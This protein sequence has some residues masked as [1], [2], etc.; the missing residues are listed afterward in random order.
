VSRVQVTLVAQDSQRVKVTWP[1]WLPYDISLPAVD[2]CAREI[3]RHL[4]AL[5]DAA[6]DNRLMACAKTLSAI[7]TVGNDLYLALFTKISGDG[8]PARIRDY[9]E[10]RPDIE[11]QFF[12][13]NMIFVPWGL[14]Y[15]SD[16]SSLPEVW[17]NDAA[18]L[19]WE[20]YLGFWCF[21]RA[22][23]ITYDRVEM[24]AVGD[25]SA[26]RMMCVVNP[27]VLA[28]AEQAVMAMPEKGLLHWLTENNP[29]SSWKTL[30]A[31]WQT[32][33]AKVGLLYFYCHASAT[34]LALG[35]EEGIDSTQLFTLLANGARRSKGTSNCL[36]VVNGCSTA[37]GGPAGNFIISTSEGPVC[38]FVGTETDVPDIFALRFSLALIHHIFRGGLSLAEAMQRLYRDHFPLSLVYGYCAHPDFRMSQTRAPDMTTVQPEN[39]SFGRVGSNRLEYIH[40]V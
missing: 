35:A 8:V 29:I 5:V 21:S 9:Y 7:A 31:R 36:V 40:G 2:R 20:T 6:V 37:V 30:R 18:A 26:L 19:S 22:I 17:P 38:G 3:R 14:V 34:M 39:F 32:E 33:N 28:K 15:P 1:G 11:F 23:A 12:V 24:D 4:K 10:K 27:D 16:P 25:T 13:S